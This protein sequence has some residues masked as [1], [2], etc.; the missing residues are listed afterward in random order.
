[1]PERVEAGG[2]ERLESDRSLPQSH[3][4]YSTHLYVHSF[5]CAT[6]LWHRGLALLHPSFF[7][8]LV[9]VSAASARLSLLTFLRRQKLQATSARCFR[10]RVATSAMLNVS[11]KHQV[12]HARD[13]GS[14]FAKRSRR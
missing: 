6:Q 10:L 5:A 1:M 12:R 11:G 2:L 4:S 3:A 9:V 13:V 8:W 14:R 7:F